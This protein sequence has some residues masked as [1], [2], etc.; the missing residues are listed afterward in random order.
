MPFCPRLFRPRRPPR[1]HAVAA[2]NTPL[3]AP[4]NRIDTSRQVFQ[5]TTS[6]QHVLA[7]TDPTG[8]LPSPMPP[9]VLYSE[10]LPH[11]DAQAEEFP[12]S[13]HAISIPGP[14]QASAT[15]PFEPQHHTPASNGNSTPPRR[16]RLDHFLESYNE[17]GPDVVGRSNIG[18]PD[19]SGGDHDE[20]SSDQL[21][22]SW[23]P[24]DADSLFT[25]EFTL[26][27]LLH[28]MTV[29][30]RLRVVQLLSADPVFGGSLE[31]E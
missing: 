24:D 10:Q 29:D 16:K 6:E 7:D 2:P 4:L 5:V 9:A 3:N 11:D 23:R 31:A 13:R 18:S 12:T 27:L 15:S 17:D 19:T 1:S 26:V 22:G 28:G 25:G 8:T 30:Q 20:L 14:V 21:G